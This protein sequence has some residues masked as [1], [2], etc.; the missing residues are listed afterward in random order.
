LEGGSEPDPE[1][2]EER[3]QQE[4]EETEKEEEKFLNG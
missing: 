3:K 1:I 2:P 4:D